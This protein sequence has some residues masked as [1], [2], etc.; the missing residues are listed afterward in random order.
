MVAMEGEYFDPTEGLESGSRVNV[1]TREYYGHT[2]EG[3][4]TFIGLTGIKNCVVHM[5]GHSQHTMRVVP[6]DAIEPLSTLYVV[7]QRCMCGEDVAE[8][9]A[10]SDDKMAMEFKCALQDAAE[11]LIR[12]MWPE[13][14]AT[15]FAGSN[16][17]FEVKEEEHPCLKR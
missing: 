7:R 3:P 15:A 11:K 4:A 5:D 2:V 17:E 16:L 6:C 9:I 14:D 12:K 10:F 8:G 13:G 1:R